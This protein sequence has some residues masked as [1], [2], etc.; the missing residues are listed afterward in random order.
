VVCQ[1]TKYQKTRVYFL[2]KS[3]A[4]KRTQFKM[5]LEHLGKDVQNS[6]EY[7]EEQKKGIGL[8]LEICKFSS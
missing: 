1:F 2:G 8:E 6:V 5:P 3:R 4:R 7:R